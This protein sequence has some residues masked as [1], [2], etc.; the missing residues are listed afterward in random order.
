MNGAILVVDD[1]AAQRL[2]VTTVLEPMAEA[3]GAQVREAP[4]AERALDILGGFPE[5]LP[6]LVLTDAV[7]PGM[8]GPGLVRAARQR[9]PHRPTRYVLF[10]AHEGKHFADV[11][12]ELGIDAVVTKP[13]GIDALRAALREQLEQ[14]RARMD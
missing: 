4:T 2:V 9:F 8:T 3:L 1:Q 12:V 10:T 6:V 11:R 13:V 7:M 14:W 5:D